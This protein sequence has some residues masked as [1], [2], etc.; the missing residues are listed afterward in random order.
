METRVRC[1]HC[2][3]WIRSPIDFKDAATF[4]SG[5]LHGNTLT[6]PTCGK[7]TPLDK[8][9]MKARHFEGL[10]GGFIGIEIVPPSTAAGEAG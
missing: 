1:K 6:C 9:N 4:D 2:E 7:E 8:A 3:A 10:G 5:T